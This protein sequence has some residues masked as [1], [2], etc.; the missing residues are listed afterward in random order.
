MLGDRSL[1][2]E[3]EFR[4]FFPQYHESIRAER[5]SEIE[6]PEE[7]SLEEARRLNGWF[8]KNR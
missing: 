3:T 2:P 6:M 1:A 4:H 8:V 7:A 5:I